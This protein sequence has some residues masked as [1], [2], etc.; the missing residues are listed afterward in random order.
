MAVSFVESPEQRL[1]EAADAL[2]TSLPTFILIESF[3]L[4]IPFRPVIVYVAVA[5]GLAITVSPVV[6]FSPTPGLQV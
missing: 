2:T 6:T 4:H 3:E 5:A 1:L